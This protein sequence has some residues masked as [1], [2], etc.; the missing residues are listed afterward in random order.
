MTFQASAAEPLAARARAWSRSCLATVC[1]VS[2]PWEHG[3]VLR[4]TRYP[5]YYD[6][7]LVRVEDEPGVGVEELTAFADRALDGLG[8]R[9]LDFDLIEAAEARRAELVEEGWKATRL[10]WMRHELAPP[11]GPEIEVREVGYDA[12]NEL[13]RR[14]H[15]EDFGEFEYERFRIAAREVAMTRQV[16]VLAVHEGGRPVAF[17]QL[18]QIGAGTE[19]TNVY[20]DPDHR[21]E[22]RGTAMTRAA[23]LTGGSGELWI[24]ADDEDRPKQLYERLGFA[25]AWTAMQFLRLV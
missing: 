18:E 12:V 14:W 10:L 24:V 8:H 3:T 20:V 2:V 21:G 22:G 11:A 6:L 7:N 13:R 5:T 4:A 25:P 16:R 23:I 19:I 9:R 17:A 15:D 1:D